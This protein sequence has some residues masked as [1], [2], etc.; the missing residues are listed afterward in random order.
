MNIKFSIKNVM[1]KPVMEGGDIV[2]FTGSTETFTHATVRECVPTA[3]NDKGEEILTFNT[4]MDV[5]KVDFY[6]WLNDEEKEIMKKEI[7][8][9]TPLITKFYGGPLIV[10]DTNR[11]FWTTPSVNNLKIVNNTEEIYFDT[12][13]P[14]AAL[15]YLSIMSGAF[16]DVVA[17]TKEWAEKHQLPHYLLLEKDDTFEG[18]DEITRSD[19]HAALGKLRKEESNEALFALAWCLQYDTNAFAGMLRSI[20]QKELINSHIKYID[21]KLKVKG[22]RK[23]NF[24]Q[25]F[26]D[27]A[28]KWE[29]TKTR[30]LVMAEAYVRGGEYFNFLLK[31]D[32]KYTTKDGTVLGN[33]VAE[34]VDKLMKADNTEE[35]EQLRDAVE[36]KWKE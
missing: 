3:L 23:R 34:A 16:M 19:A 22:V 10:K 25:T 36:A 14:S 28:E 24:P 15:L 33:T 13:K 26:I 1:G 30:E 27:Y 7:E 2:R 31:R 18:E 32:K 6:G 35:F 29:K 20:P 11:Y 17:P 4:G 8:E 9:L 21:G 5:D 12:S